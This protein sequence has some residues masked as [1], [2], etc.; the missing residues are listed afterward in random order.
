MSKL[1]FFSAQKSSDRARLSASRLPRSRLRVVFRLPANTSRKARY[2]PYASRWWRRY[3]LLSPS[4]WMIGADMP[5]GSSNHVREG[6]L[7]AAEVVR[8]EHQQPRCHEQREC[9]PAIG[10]RIADSEQR[11]TQPVDDEYHRVQIKGQSPLRW[12][13]R[14][15]E[16][17]WRQ[18]QPELYN[19]RDHITH[20]AIADVEG[21]Q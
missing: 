13:N 15:A 4:I 6:P 7:G 17:N 19:E 3:F 5:A 10:E 14:R 21:T 20:V 16:P 9:P 12:H 2:L 11:P 8:A 18:K 1:T